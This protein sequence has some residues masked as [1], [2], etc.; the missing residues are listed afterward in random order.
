MYRYGIICLHANGISLSLG[1]R[2][3]EWTFTDGFIM[4]L[5]HSPTL[6]H[7]IKT[8][9]N[10]NNLTSPLLPMITDCIICKPHLYCH[11]SQ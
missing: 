7:P 8:Q 2:L 6:P 5:S 1:G 9:S 10:C 4:F 11:T 3:Q